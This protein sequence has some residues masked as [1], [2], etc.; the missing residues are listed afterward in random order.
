MRRIDGRVASDLI[1]WR[2]PFAKKKKAREGGAS[3]AGLVL[4]VDVVAVLSDDLSGL[5][6]RH[7]HRREHGASGDQGVEFGHW[8]ALEF[9]VRRG[10]SGDDL[11]GLVQRGEGHRGEHSA[12]GDQGVKL[13]HWLCSSVRS[14]IASMSKPTKGLIAVTEGTPQISDQPLAFGDLADIRH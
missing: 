4:P 8:T 9:G 1:G 11:R 2:Q 12:G 13:G 5:V 6:E 10:R 7:R 3:F 14:V